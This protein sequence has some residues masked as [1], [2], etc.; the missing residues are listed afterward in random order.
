LLKILFAFYSP[1]GILPSAMNP[2]CARLLCSKLFRVPI[3]VTKRDNLAFEV[4]HDG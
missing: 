2:R 1:Y 3:A 4:N